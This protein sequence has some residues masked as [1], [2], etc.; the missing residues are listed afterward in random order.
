MYS[1]LFSK[2][3]SESEVVHAISGVPQGSVL[4]PLLFLV[5]INDLCHISLSHGSHTVLYADDLV[6]YKVIG[7]NSC[8]AYGSMQEDI[9]RIAEWTNV[10]LLN[11][12]RSKCKAMLISRRQHQHQPHLFYLQGDNIEQ[13]CS[14]KYLGVM[15]TSNLKWDEHIDKVSLKTKRL[16]GHL[17]RVFYRNVQP[18][19]LLNLYISLV[20]PH[21]EYACQV[22]DPYIATEE[23]LPTRGHTKVCTFCTGQWNT[24]YGDLLENYHLPRLSNR[25]EYLRLATLFQIHTHHF[26]FPPGILTQPRTSYLNLLSPQDI[27]CLCHSLCTYDF[28][29]TIFHPSNNLCL[30]PL[31]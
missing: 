30:E 28:I 11:F 31:A 21:L 6:L 29:S 7:S 4:G 12:N 19:Y 16:L 27:T 18:Q 25:R 10:N 8:S 1:L 14:Y 3:G 2:H 26:H 20:R 24:R 23:Y 13:V 5:Y 15:V 22:W 9:D 17:Y